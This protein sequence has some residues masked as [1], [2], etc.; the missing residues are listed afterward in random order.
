[1]KS[2]V[3]LDSELKKKVDKLLKEGRKIEAIAMVQNELRLGLKGS[4]DL[5]DGLGKMPEQQAK[6]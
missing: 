1:M 6:S 3:K 5:V 4:K 2:E